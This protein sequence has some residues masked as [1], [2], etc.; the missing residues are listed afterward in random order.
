MTLEAVEKV[1]MF[2][3]PSP[4]GPAAGL[5]VGVGRP[6]R[7]DELVVAAPVAGEQVRGEGV[8]ADVAGGDRGDVDLPES[9]SSLLC[10]RVPG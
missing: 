5:L 4:A 2:R 8:S 1:H 6:T 9:L 10:V 7:F 3:T